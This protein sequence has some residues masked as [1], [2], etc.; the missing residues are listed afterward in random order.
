MTKV[1]LLNL[2][3]TIS[4]EKIQTEIPTLMVLEP[5]Q[6]FLVSAAA[7][8]RLG[9]PSPFKQCRRAFMSSGVAEG[10]ESGK[11]GLKVRFESQPHGGNRNNQNQQQLQD[12][13]NSNWLSENPELVNI[14]V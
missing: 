6:R 9:P 5:E 7:D 12:H 11:S 3:F 13:L 1:C 14:H 8:L 4:I 2:L 10:A